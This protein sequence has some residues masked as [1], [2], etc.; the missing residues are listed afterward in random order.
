MHEN[1]FL[2][3]EIQF[4]STALICLLSRSVRLA[5]ILEGKILNYVFVQVKLLTHTFKVSL[6]KY[7]VIERDLFRVQQRK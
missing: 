3:F 7:N 5:T 6:T 2:N 1:R 4:E